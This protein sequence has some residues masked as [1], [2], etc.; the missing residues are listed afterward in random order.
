MLMKDSIAVSNQRC[1][2]LNLLGG[3]T[4]FDPWF[5]Q[6]KVKRHKVQICKKSNL[7]HRNYYK[8]K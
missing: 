6:Y 4:L 3:A 1:I 2:P 7:H 5:T 8:E